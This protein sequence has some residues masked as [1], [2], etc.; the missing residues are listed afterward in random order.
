MGRKDEM[1][2][3]LKQRLINCRWQYFDDHIQTSKIEC[4]FL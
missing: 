2:K 1:V 3:V 4:V